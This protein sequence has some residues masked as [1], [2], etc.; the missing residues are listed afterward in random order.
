M[1]ALVIGGT[2]L[3]S[4]GITRELL[5]RGHK[6]TVFHRGRTPLRERGVMEILGDRRD[7]P[8]FEAAL[9]PF[10]WDA[11]FDLI[12]FNRDDVASAERALAGRTKHY[13]FCSTVCAVGVPTLKLV[14]DETE[15]YHPISGYGLGK[16]DAERYLL[17]RWKAK[18]FPVTIFRPSHTYGPGGGW[19]LGTFM[20]DWEWDT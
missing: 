6:V 14:C 9:R 16:A 20:T 13:L 15:P 18:R 17:G 8:L 2:G 19:V 10:K 7:R 5:R 11:V 4:G 1:N 3:I 12:A